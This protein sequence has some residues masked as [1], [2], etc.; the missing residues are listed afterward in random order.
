MRFSRSAK[1]RQLT[2]QEVHFRVIVLADTVRGFCLGWQSPYRHHRMRFLSPPWPPVAAAST[3]VVPLSRGSPSP[4]IPNAAADPQRTHAGSTSS[5]STRKPPAASSATR[6][7]P[8]F[9][10][11]LSGFAL[12]VRLI[13]LSIYSDTTRKST[14]SSI[15]GNP[16]RSSA[17][18]KLRAISAW[19]QMVLKRRR[20]RRAE[21]LRGG[22]KNSMLKGRQKCLQES[23]A[24]PLLIP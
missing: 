18:Q 2:E 11:G 24:G 17:L 12:C 5:A 9:A 21:T 19:L 8:S 20:G 10:H 15:I 1:S 6:F 16:K 23:A 22:Q 7:K 13:W 3:T 4:K 14:T